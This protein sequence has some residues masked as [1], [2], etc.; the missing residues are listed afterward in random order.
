MG[1]LN[2]IYQKLIEVGFVENGDEYKFEHVQQQQII[3]NGVPHVNETKRVIRVKYIGD[4]CEL[5]EDNN[6]I[7]GTEM[8]GFNIYAGEE[9]TYPE[10][11][12]YVTD[13][14]QLGQILGF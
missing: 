14:V 12:V 13:H 9:S 5:D 6:N 1:N 8:F 2:S 4:G 7:D 10:T 11:T 3:I